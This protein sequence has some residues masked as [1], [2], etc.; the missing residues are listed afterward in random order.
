MRKTSVA[1]LYASLA[2]AAFSFIT[3]TGAFAQ[4]NRPL[5]YSSTRPTMLEVREQLDEIE[6]IN[7]IPIQMSGLR[8]GPD[9]NVKWWLSNLVEFAPRFIA[10]AEKTFPGATWA[11]IGRDVQAWADLFE[12]FYFTLGQKDRV[13]RIGM[14]RETLASIKPGETNPVLPFLKNHGFSLEN[15]GAQPPFIFI[16]TISKG[17]GRQG[18]TLLAHIYEQFVNEG[19]NPA[20]LLDKFN[21]LGMLV[22]TFEGTE[23]PFQNAP[24]IL[25]EQKVLFSTLKTFP[26]FFK[27][28]RIITYQEPGRYSN[29][30]G[31]EHFTG[32]W[33][34]KFG[35]FVMQA[36]GSVD[37][38]P[39]MVSDEP[40]RQTILW[41]Q[42]QLWKE[43]SDP[44]FLT[45]VKKA[46]VSLGYSFPIARPVNLRGI[47]SA[48]ESEV[49]D[50]LTSTEAKIQ[51]MVLH[52]RLELYLKMIRRTWWTRIVHFLFPQ[53][54]GEA[55][56]L[57]R[58]FETALT[59][60]GADA[61][62]LALKTFQSARKLHSEGV[63]SDRSLLSLLRLVLEWSVPSEQLVREIQRLD[64]QKLIDTQKANWTFN[65]LSADPKNATDAMTVKLQILKLALAITPKDNCSKLLSEANVK[66]ERL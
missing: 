27:N 44:K 47:D 43:V 6:D 9:G 34:G 11:F 45:K 25:E 7:G 16:D 36:D 2:I 63:V 55:L 40:V 1:V 54:Q 26:D 42:K 51:N 18:R 57:K 23:N 21:M 24:K 13:V 65:S 62:F 64:D 20:L 10:A 50:L 41:F 17:S 5:L 28:F 22:R 59:S 30:S 19:K 61:D 15:I 14:S 12:A 58:W 32:A 56:K 37:A 29:E 39:G 35:P 60:P 4:G 38:P 53:Y 8:D 49:R 66:T 52:P 33:H 46:A 31:Y 3:S 48:S